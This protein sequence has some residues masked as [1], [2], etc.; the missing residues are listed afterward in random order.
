MTPVTFDSLEALSVYLCV[1][2]ARE[3]VLLVSRFMSEMCSSIIL[4]Y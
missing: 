1:T 3:A 4:L 2:T